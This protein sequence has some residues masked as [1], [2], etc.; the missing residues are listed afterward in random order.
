MDIN[1]SINF[2]DKTSAICQHFIKVSN[3]LTCQCSHYN[4]DTAATV[5][6][7]VAIS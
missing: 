7:Q 4:Y 5:D 6:I 2:W 1:N 3:V